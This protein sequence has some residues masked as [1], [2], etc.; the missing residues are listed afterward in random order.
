MVAQR[1]QVGAVL[2]SPR[3]QEAADVQAAAVGWLRGGEEGEELVG[4]YRRKVGAVLMRL[5]EHRLPSGMWLQISIDALPGPRTIRIVLSEEAARSSKLMFAKIVHPVETRAY[6]W[7]AYQGTDLY[8]WIERLVLPAE[9]VARGLHIFEIRRETQAAARVVSMA[10]E[11]EE[12]EEHECA[13]TAEYK[14]R[15]ALTMRVHVLRSP[16]RED[17][18]CIF[19]TQQLLD[20]PPPGWPCTGTSVESH[21]NLL[22]ESKPTL[23][24]SW[25]GHQWSALKAEWGEEKHAVRVLDNER[26][27]ESVAYRKRVRA[28][29]TLVERW[30]P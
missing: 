21:R 2:G 22:H 16:E 10:E 14:Q 17:P 6:V 20:L 24:Q 1:H 8:A 4:G 18:P 15:W 26:H 19:D 28:A 9:I 25:A 12:A 3:C 13:Q 5:V 23:A 7:E 29:Q 27:A 30:V 11:R